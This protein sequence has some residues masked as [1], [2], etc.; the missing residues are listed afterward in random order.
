MTLI[1]KSEFPRIFRVRQKFDAPTCSDIKNTVATE[2]ERLQLANKVAAGES[3]AI[4]AGSRG[5]SNIAEIIQAIAH[6]FLEAKAK[7]FIVPSMGSHGGGTSAGQ[8]QV[9]ESYGITESFCGCPIKDSMETVTIG[10]AAEGFPIYFDKSSSEADHVIVCGRIKPHTNFSGDIQ[11]GLMKMMMIG[12]GKKDGAALYHRAIHQH[13]FPQIIRSV[14]PKVV[15]HANIL[16]GVAIVENA[17]DETALIEAVLPEDFQSRETEL[18]KQARQWMPSLPFEDLDV[19]LIDQIGKNISGT[20]MDTNVIGR[21]HSEHGPPNIKRLVVR[22]LTN[23]THGNATGIGF[24]E[25]C[26]SRVIEKMNRE[27]T[28]LNCLTALDIDAAKIPVNFP[29][30]EQAIAT[31]LS[32]LGL[33]PPSE[34]RLMWIHNTGELGEVVCS[35]ALRSEVDAS[36]SLE[37]ISESFALPIDSAGMLPDDFLA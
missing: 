19:L 20:G 32:T 3:V 11:S 17:K 5:I 35:E 27:T 30:D 15:E 4:T 9:I 28:V 24:A 7:P 8:R 2:L 21:K 14:A 12:L 22:D 23:E 26:L 10:E 1:P 34:S 25:L 29:T 18:L 16:A 6:F 33:R 31:A 13:G 37:A 36:P